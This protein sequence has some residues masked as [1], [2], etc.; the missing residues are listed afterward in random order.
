[1]HNPFENAPFFESATSYR[2]KTKNPE[3][4]FVT[5]FSSSNQYPVSSLIQSL[6]H[7]LPQTRVIV[8]LT[9]L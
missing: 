3:F 1:V 6:F 8:A 9:P 5:S 4:E 7:Q 2:I